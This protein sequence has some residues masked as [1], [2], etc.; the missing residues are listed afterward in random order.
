MSSRRTRPV[1]ATGIPDVRMMEFLEKYRRK[2]VDEDTGL[3]FEPSAKARGPFTIERLAFR[4]GP[5][6]RLALRLFVPMCALVFTFSF[7][8]DWHSLLRSCSV[9]GAI[10]FGTNW[11]AIK[12]LF[13]PREARPVFGHGLIPSQRDQLIEKVANEV[14][15]KLI[16]ETLI[17]RKIEETQLVQRFTESTIEKLRVISRDPEFERDLRNMILT[18]VSDQIGRAHV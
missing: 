15:E 11:I 5:G 3:P 16:N 4:T 14:L 12:M 6:L 2:A 8:W 7:L 10:G 13:W 18:Y 1:W 17:L 9:A